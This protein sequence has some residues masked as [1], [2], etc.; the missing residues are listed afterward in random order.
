MLELDIP[1]DYI[2]RPGGHSWDYWGNAVEYQL[3]FF[4]KLFNNGNL[5]INNK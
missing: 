1:H 4:S 2:E 3:L 5:K